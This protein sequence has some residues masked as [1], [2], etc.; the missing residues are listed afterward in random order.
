P[1]ADGLA[2]GGENLADLLDRADRLGSEVGH[3]AEQL[4]QVQDGHPVEP[5]RRD[6]LSSWYTSKN[7]PDAAG[8]RSPPARLSRSGT[9]P[10]RDPAHCDPPG[11]RQAV[12]G[13]SGLTSWSAHTTRPVQG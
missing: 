11:R 8:L 7:R 12:Q 13:C 6:G 3:R 2:E 4:A 5:P 1:A 9:R 10:C